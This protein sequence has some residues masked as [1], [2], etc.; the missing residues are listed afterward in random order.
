MTLDKTTLAAVKQADA[1][2]QQA[3]AALNQLSAT[4]REALAIATCGSLP[5]SL[6]MAADASRRLL[7][8][9]G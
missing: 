7:T 9:I 2:I 3:H 8:H 1:L 5:D 6:A 4:Q